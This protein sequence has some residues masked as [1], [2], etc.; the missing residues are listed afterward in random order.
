[1]SNSVPG[2]K[3]SE[4]P[5]GTWYAPGVQPPASG[6]TPGS[7]SAPP[8][9][10]EQQYDPQRYGP[11][12]YDP[13]QYEPAPPGF[14]GP[15]QPPTLPL[16]RA[17]A[18]SS[19]GSSTGSSSTGRTLALALVAVAVVTGVVLVAA[20]GVV[21]VARSNRQADPPTTEPAVAVDPTPTTAD[22]T[23]VTDDTGLTEEQRRAAAEARQ[24]LLTYPTSRA[25]L[26]EHLTESDEG[27]EYS[28]ADATVAVDSLGVDW[29][30]VAAVA[31]ED[32]VTYSGYSRDGLIHQMSSEYGGGFTLDQATRAV[33]GLTV[34]WD[35]EAIEYAQ[36]YVDDF[37]ISRDTLVERMTSESGGF[38]RDQ[39]EQAIAQITVDW[40][41][42]AVMV[43]ERILENQT[44][45]TCQELIEEL[46]G[47]YGRGFT[48]E[49]AQYA[50]ES[51]DLC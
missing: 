27:G 23:D 14:A 19:T 4:Q 30:A 3:P 28:V 44:I 17:G 21:L 29:D 15:T 18:P 33:D 6:P 10:G 42:Q 43:T 20:I 41:E 31:A 7:A 38:S 40:N 49:Q 24:Y 45:A 16:I 37:G 2:D 22:L 5:Q 34:D 47:E 48:P 36:D 25:R 9:S 46:A 39:A 35:A 13:Q 1:M 26:I 32:Y 50:A 51:T 12:Q 8:P 11:Q